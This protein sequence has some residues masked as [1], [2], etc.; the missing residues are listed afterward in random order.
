MAK[1]SLNLNNPTISVS[2]NRMEGEVLLKNLAIGN[3]KG[4]GMNL[5]Q[6]DI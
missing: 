6:E 1:E 2:L 5:K 3:G 4:I